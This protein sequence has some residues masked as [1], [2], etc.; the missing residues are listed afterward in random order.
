L[1]PRREAIRR[2]CRAIRTP[3]LRGGSFPRGLWMGP[4]GRWRRHVWGVSI[5]CFMGPGWG[6]DAWGALRGDLGALIS[7]LLSG[8]VL[9]QASPWLSRGSSEVCGGWNLAYWKI[10]YFRGRLGTVKVVALRVRSGPWAR[11]GMVHAAIGTE[12][13]WIAEVLLAVRGSRGRAR[14]LGNQL[15]FFYSPLAG[16]DRNPAALESDEA[17]ARAIPKIFC[18]NIVRRPWQGGETP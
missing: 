12:R 15:L 18:T 1:D 8:A 7:M 11:F 17:R 10:P 2:A 6:A 4:I 9:W 13:G 3:T 14:R 5:P 16:F